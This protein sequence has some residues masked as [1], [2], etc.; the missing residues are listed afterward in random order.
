MFKKDDVLICINASKIRHLTRGKKYTV[1]RG[2]EKGIYPDR[3]Y[4][5]VD[6]DGVVVVCHAS[7]FKLKEN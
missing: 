3:P 2:E 4:V 1:L 6:A 7:R 5:T